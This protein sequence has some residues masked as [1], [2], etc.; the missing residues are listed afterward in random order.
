MASELPN[1]YDFVLT[2]KSFDDDV[3]AVI[4]TKLCGKFY[5]DKNNIDCPIVWSSKYDKLDNN[6]TGFDIINKLFIILN[7]QNESLNYMREKYVNNQANLAEVDIYNIFIWCVS[8][9]YISAVIDI[10]KYLENSVDSKY[11]QMIMSGMNM[12]KQLSYNKITEILSKIE[13]LSVV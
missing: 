12:S 13:S 7:F 6:M 10:L 9:N 3:S 1:I 8:K 11:Y 5:I 4:M 2:N